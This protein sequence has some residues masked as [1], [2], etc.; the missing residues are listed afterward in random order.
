MPHSLLFLSVLSN[1]RNPIELIVTTCA[2]GT[3]R[4]F[5]AIDSHVRHDSR[6]SNRPLSCKSAAVIM[7]QEACASLP[8]WARSRFFAGRLWLDAIGG[9]LGWG[10]DG[11]E[12][13]QGRGGWQ[14]AAWKKLPAVSALPTSATYPFPYNTVE[15][16]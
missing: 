14:A 8:C 6:P 1:C 10:Q 9:W 2:C 15:K 16:A 11:E 7:R 3:Q 5:P 12:S 4:T 13:I